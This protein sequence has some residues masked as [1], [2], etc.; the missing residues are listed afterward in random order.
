MTDERVK[1][2]ELATVAGGP[3]ADVV[4]R[5]SA[6]TAFLRG[7]TPGATTPGGATTKAT[8]APKDDAKATAAAKAAATAAG[9]ANGATAPTGK[10]NG[11]TP[12][13][14]AAAA[15][16]GGVP[17]QPPSDTK[18]PGGAHTYADVINKLRA[19]LGAE[20]VAAT[21]E[22]R[23]VKAFGV[24]ATR[25]GGVKIA[26]DLK[27]TL[28]DAVVKGCD[29]LLATPK[30]AAAPAEDFDSLGDPPEHTGGGL[31]ADADSLEDLTKQPERN[32]MGLTD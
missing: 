4:A 22:E 1:A 12:P 20:N 17:A 19:V 2:L 16:K 7:T 10:A 24:L 29:A 11:A 3:P 6:Y 25:G 8:A 26:R 30:Q 21:P 27:P 23:R 31:A 5:A 9:K 14:G 13:K 15:A 28:Y 18:G 32:E